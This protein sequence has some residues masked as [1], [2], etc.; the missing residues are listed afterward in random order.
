LFKAVKFSVY[1]C[2]R[3]TEAR[4]ALLNPAAEGLDIVG[5]EKIDPTV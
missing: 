4:D 3:F 1:F 5:V 2:S